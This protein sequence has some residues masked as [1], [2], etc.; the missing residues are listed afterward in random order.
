M[1]VTSTESLSAT[2]HAGTDEGLLIRL[3]EDGWL[4]DGMVRAGMRRLI[5]Q[6]LVDEGRDD[7]ELCARRLDALI[8]E[9]RASPIAI[10][11]DVANTQ[12]Y[13][14][15]ASFFAAHLGPHLK[16]SCCLYPR[17]TETLAQA[18]EAMLELYAQRAELADGQRILDL[19]CGWG[20]LSLWLAARYPKSSI[21]ALSN[22]RGQRA[23]IEAQAARKGLNNLTVVTC[24]IADAGIAGIAGMPADGS[25]DR[26][27]SIE[28][29]EHVKNYGALLA[30]IAGWM[31]PG[32]RLFVH[33]FAHRMLAYHFEVRDRS[34]WMSKYFFTGG[35]MPSETLLLNFQDDLR[36][37]RRWWV[38][39]S[40]YACTANAWLARLDA[41]RASVMPTLVETYGARDAARWFQRWRMFYMAVAELFGYEHGN[42][43]GVAHYLFEK[44]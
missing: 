8:D 20:S 13:E 34:D 1:P 30:R 15:P 9:L 37:A 14:M 10:A 28:M 5:R 18:E 23:F 7:G 43:W 3:C 17:G 21:V 22:S 6:R 4:P 32:G 31:C 40:H 24:D 27:L 35:T 25:F 33:L 36:V 16:Y 39:G 44:R 19:G 29:F 42:E 12:H 41:V 38:S 2:A 26:V 11:T